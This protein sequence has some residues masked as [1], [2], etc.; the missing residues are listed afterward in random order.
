MK[1]ENPHKSVGSG[2]VEVTDESLHKEVYADKYFRAYR[3]DIVPGQSTDYHR[4]SEDTLYIVINGGRMA[5]TNFKGHKR[6]PMIFPQSFPLY[7]K[8]WFALQN[9]FT[10]SVHLP[11]GLFFFMPTKKYPSIHLAAASP[12]NRDAVR[13]MGIEMRYSATD[14]LPPIHHTLPGR[15]EFDN[16]VLKVLVCCLGPDASQEI[17]IPGYHLF[18]MC[19]K[20][21]LEITPEPAKKSAT[22]RLAKGDYLRV[23]GNFPATAKNTANAASELIIL[24]IS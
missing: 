20:G 23:S 3:A 15:V 24:S 19:T 12:H 21:S 2:Y 4:H 8:L 17:A 9:V 18:M 11:D 5:N 7:K 10:G 6:S 22:S 14:T 1:P 16:G 13:L